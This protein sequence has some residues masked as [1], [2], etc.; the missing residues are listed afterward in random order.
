MRI[1]YRR[2]EDFQPVDIDRLR[3][4]GSYDQLIE[5]RSHA[6]DGLIAEYGKIPD[7]LLKSRV[8]PLCGADDFRDELHKDHLTLVRCNPCGHVYVNPVFD[9]EHYKEIYRSEDYQR[10][11]RDLGEASHAYRVER[12]GKERVGIMERFFDLR[13]DAKPRYLD[14]G[15]STGFVVEAARDRDWNAMGVDLNP[16]AIEFGRKRGLDLFNGALEDMDFEPGSFD[17]VSLFDVLEHLFDPRAIAEAAVRLLRPGGLLF[18]Y[19]PNYDSASRILMGSEAHFI[20]PTHHLNYYNIQTAADFLERLGLEIA[21]VQTEGL[22]IAD[23]I[24]RESGVENKDTA[25]LEEIA[26]KLQFFI[27]AGGYGKNLRILG[28]LRNVGE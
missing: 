11:V 23:F 19:L 12:F 22:D 21:F 28:R 15:C 1:P 6:I 17:A 25:L 14:I 2:I 7:D 5:K 20:W 8:C 27:N 24:W 10:I 9:E 13:E 26:D 16:S 3:P 4:K 18:L